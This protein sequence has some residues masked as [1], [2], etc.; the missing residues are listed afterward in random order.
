MKEGKKTDST[1]AIIE[2][3]LMVRMPGEVDHHNATEIRIRTDEFIMGDEVDHVIFDFENT[4]FMDSSG[5]GVLMGRYKKLSL[6]GGR[7]MAIHV[8]ER[9]KKIMKMAGI[10]E[11]IEIL[12]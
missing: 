8:N 2:R 6:F 10:L 7:V 4:V 5:I 3:H 12:D 9:L 1:F 11:F